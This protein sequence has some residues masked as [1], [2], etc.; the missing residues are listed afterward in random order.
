MLNNGR[1][2]K[3]RTYQS[4]PFFE[5]FG[6]SEPLSVRRQSGPFDEQNV[7][8]VALDTLLKLMP[9]VAFWLA[10]DVLGFA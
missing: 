6:A 2:F 1:I 9:D 7:A 3:K 8:I 10:N 4:P 5:Q